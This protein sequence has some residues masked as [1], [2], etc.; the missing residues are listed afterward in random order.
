M[1]IA[2][3]GA[4]ANCKALLE[5]LRG[6][7]E[8]C[9]TEILD[10]YVRGIRYGH[11][12]K[13]PAADG[14][15]GC[16]PD[17]PIIVAIGNASQAIRVGQGLYRKGCQSVYYYLNKAKSFTSDFFLGEC[18]KIPKEGSIIPSLEMHVVDFCNLNCAGCIH[19]SPIFDRKFPDFEKRIS[20]IRKIKALVDDVFM[21][22]LM[23]GEPLLNPDL[24]RYIVEARKRLPSSEIQLITNGL[25]LPR[26][27]DVLLD[28]IRENRVTVSVSEYE[29]THK[30]ISSIRNSLERQQ[31]DYVIRPYSRKHDFNRPLSVKE[32]SVHEKRCI[33]DGCIGVCDGKIARCPALLYIGRFNQVFRQHLPEQGIW[34]ISDFSSGDELLRRMEERVP[35]CDYCVSDEMAWHTCGS[36]PQLTDF[37]ALD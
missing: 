3:Y 18:K 34:E 9:V 11:E 27:K 7:P 29:P 31:V 24:G 15:I 16:P 6:Y 33:C 30:M 22:S 35:L 8:I 14:S 10:S 12:V 1:N 20:D 25:L 36:T 2:V 23:G 28:T 17:T 4:G 21:F 19:Y 32:G 37:A 5:K 26:M 13:N